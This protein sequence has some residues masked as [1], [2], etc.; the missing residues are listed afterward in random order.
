MSGDELIQRLRAQLAPYKC[1]K[2]IFFT[3]TLPKSAVGK[4]LRKELRKQYAP[5]N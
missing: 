1:P 3:S 2:A 5:A 4:V